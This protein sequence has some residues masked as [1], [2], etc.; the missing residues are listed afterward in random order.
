MS[1]RAKELSSEFFE[2][3]VE[4]VGVG[5]GIYGA[6]GCYLYVNEAYADM[7][8]TDRNLLVGKPL[9][10]IVPTLEDDRFDSYWE[11]FADGETRRAKTEHVYEDV[12]VPV[13]TV[14]TRRR[15]GGTPY[16]FGTIQDISAQKAYEKNLERKNERLEAFTGVVG[17][18]LRNPL[19]VAEGY[20]DLAQSECNSEHLDMIGSALTRME[21]LLDDLLT[22]A[23]E[24]QTIDEKEPVVVEDVAR[25][26]W[27]NVRTAD[28][29]IRI[30]DGSVIRADRERLLQ[31]FE[32]LFRNS[33]EHSSTTNHTD[34]H[35]EVGTISDGFYVAD[36]GPGI[37]EE[38][39]ETLFRAGTT[40][41]EDGTG[42]GLAIVKEIAE[43]HGWDV[44]ALEGDSGGARFE[45][46]GAELEP[47]ADRP[48]SNEPEDSN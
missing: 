24:G 39:R 17:H 23:R 47:Q 8:D 31:I 28:A 27:N 32:N 45:I 35:T 4:S 10:E 21:T 29:E 12:S 7:L 30:D 44:R 25:A 15:I 33:V 2:E 1:D 40:T 37:P 42:F 16:H 3:M 20:L 22:L 43:A 19:N 18:D 41:S 13:K 34:L 5:V 26:A 14:T 48:V 38:I 9:W 46:T 36:N 6:D 11:S